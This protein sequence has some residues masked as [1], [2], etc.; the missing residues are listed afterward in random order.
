[1]AAVPASIEQDDGELFARRMVQR[2]GAPEPGDYAI[3]LFGSRGI[4]LCGSNSGG[5]FLWFTVRLLEGPRRGRELQLS[6]VI[7]GPRECPARP[8]RSPGAR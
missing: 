1:M 7:D 4:R 5:V 2:Y 3:E 8:L 6:I